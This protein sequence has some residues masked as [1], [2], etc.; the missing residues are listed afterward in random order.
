L[1]PTYGVVVGD[2]LYE[3]TKKLL[4]DM[5]A[6]AVN[7]PAS[8]AKDSKSKGAEDVANHLKTQSTKCPNQKYVLIGYSQGADVMHNGAA[9][10][11]ASLF[12]RIVAL[13][14]YGDP[15]RLFSSLRKFRK[16]KLMSILKEISNR[17]QYLR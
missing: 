5:T 7:Y 4:P 3:D 15:G 14:M 1:A 13:V 6:Y 10:I 9:K 12:P 17:T 8:F 2:P 16:V 11:H